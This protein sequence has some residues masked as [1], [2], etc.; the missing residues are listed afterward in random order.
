M[1]NTTRDDAASAAT[2][3]SAVFER[4]V[5]GHA[6]RSHYERTHWV[7]CAESSDDV[8]SVIYDPNGN[9][10]THA[11]L[12]AVINELQDENAELQVYKRAMESMASQILHPKIT[13]MEMAAMQL[14]DTSSRA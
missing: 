10:M 1:M 3:G 14:S 13:A 12:C 7:H 9:A 2:D 5:V 8:R 11:E 4:L 6:G